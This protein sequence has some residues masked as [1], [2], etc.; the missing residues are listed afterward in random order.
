LQFI[1]GRDRLLKSKLWVHACVFEPRPQSPP[2]RFW[3]AHRTK[4]STSSM[5]TNTVISQSKPMMIHKSSVKWKMNLQKVKKSLDVRST[6][7][8]TAAEKYG[9]Q[10]SNSNLCIRPC[11]SA[12]LKQHSKILIMLTFLLFLF[13]SMSASD[14]IFMYICQGLRDWR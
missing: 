6:K 13:A 14:V 10:T 4:V 5:D 7:S 11:T 9:I 8:L 12:T 2:H 1:L 3:Y